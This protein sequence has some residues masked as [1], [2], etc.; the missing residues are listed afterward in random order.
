[1]EAGGGLSP[2]GVARRQYNR[3]TFK[4]V[5]TTALRLEVTMQPKV[6]AGIERWRVK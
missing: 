5:T 1:M 2:Y 6:S 4:P 3:L